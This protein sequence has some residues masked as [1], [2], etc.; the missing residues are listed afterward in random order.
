[1]SPN[2]LTNLMAR[3]DT[4]FYYSIATGGYRWTPE[5]FQH[6]NVVFFPLLPMVMRWGGALLGGHPLLAGV[7]VSHVAFAGAVALLYRLA[8][9]D[10]G[11]ALA[12][13]VV[14]LLAT[15]PYAL[16][17]SAVYTESLF[18]LFS[19]GAWYAVRRERPG[20]AALSGLAAGLT[21]PN[22]FWLTLP[23]A[24]LVGCQTRIRYV[25]DTG[26]I[27][28]RYPLRLAVLAPLAGA[29]LYSAYLWIHFGD[30]LAWMHGQAAW[31]LPLLGRGPAPDPARLP[32]EPAIKLT[33][34]IVW[35]GNIAAFGAAAAAIRPLARR[36]GAA[37]GAWIAVNIFPP[38]AAH[39]FMSLGRFTAVLFP[40]F[41]W[42]ALRVPRS[43]LLP[44]AAAFAAG[45]LILAIWFFLWQPVV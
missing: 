3:W 1:V 30:A 4:A 39:L 33:E 36:F 18:L 35:I 37:Y 17:Y 15:F 22:G 42:M 6:E 29:A 25:S 7:I 2:E 5:V 16:F 21:R 27:R 10:V 9:L 32:G 11:E 34:V 26:L 13:P 20:W 12:W 40:F 31:G 38:V 28:I 24:L 19:V 43:R 23:L 44:V 8:I 41:Y 14:L 45:Q